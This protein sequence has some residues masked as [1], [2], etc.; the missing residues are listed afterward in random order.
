MPEEGGSNENNEKIV[1]Q[2]NRF[3]DRDSNLPPSEC[4]SCICNQY[5][6][7]ELYHEMGN[8]LEEEKCSFGQIIN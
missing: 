3:S 6:W 7:F 2:V 5:I 4:K 8:S 1:R